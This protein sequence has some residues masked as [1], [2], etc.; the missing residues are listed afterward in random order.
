[1]SIKSICALG[2]ALAALF[3]VP[4]ALRAESMK[5]LGTFEAKVT[6]QQVH[7]LDAEGRVVVSELSKGT[8][9]SPGAPIDG[10]EM[11]LSENVVLDKG[12]G[13]EQGSV[14]YANDKGSIT[15]EIHGTVK[16]VMADGQPHTTISGTYKMIAGTGLFAG[17]EGHG[18][19]TANYTSK[20]DYKGEYK[21]TLKL[22]NRQAAR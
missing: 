13:P 20:T 18:T 2:T 15:N 19:F 12:N 22:P 4:V 1:M 10:A 7:P 5:V 3:A 17:G 16:T 9:K 8:T 14:S 21:G 6:Q 11:L